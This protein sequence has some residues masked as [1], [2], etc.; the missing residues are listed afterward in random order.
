MLG[1]AGSLW[2][3]AAGV[4][5]CGVPGAV[6]PMGSAGCAVGFLENQFRLGFAAAGVCSTA[7]HAQHVHSMS[8]T[9]VVYTSYHDQRQELLT[10]RVPQKHDHDKSM[11]MARA[12]RLPQ[13]ITM[14]GQT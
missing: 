10:L 2:G 7:P 1:A 4:A 6:A 12:D 5:G 8:M 3:I 13:S 9:G 14:T 11:S